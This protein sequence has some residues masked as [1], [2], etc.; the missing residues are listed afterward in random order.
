MA[1]IDVKDAAGGTQTVA[2]Y[3]PGRIAAASSAPVVLSTEDK[4][5]VDAQ[6]ASL[7]SVDGKLP[8][9]SSGRIP[10]E[11]QPT[12]VGLTD[13]QLRASAVP[14]SLAALPATAA[15]AALQTAGNASLTSIDGKLPATLGTKA[16]A[17]S[18]PVT[19]STENQALTGALTEAAPG[20]DT[21]SSGLN[22]RLQRIAQR[23]TS[24]IAQFPATIGV[25][26][27][28]ASLSVAIATDDAQIGAKTTASTIGAGGSGLIG[29]LSDAATSLATLV[30]RTRAPSAPVNRSGTITAGGTA[31]SLVAANATG[32]RF[33]LKNLHATASLWFDETGVAAVASQPSFE[34]KPGALYES[35]QGQVITGGV[36]IIGPTTGQ[37][38]YAREW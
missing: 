2:K 15:T 13:T 31:Q 4:A 10:V 29:W 11:I 6:A 32:V 35:P 12:A 20:T 14:V 21:A 18:L 33:S 27:S 30:T 17:A 34:L 26:A 5:V 37:S 36:S 25:K 1:T 19:L 8:A 28:A 9:L 22:G 16:D 38:F 7:V 3:L 24:L 23:L